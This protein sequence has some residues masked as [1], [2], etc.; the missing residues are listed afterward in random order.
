ML[1]STGESD[2]RRR[3]LHSPNSQVQQR[4]RLPGTSV[5]SRGHIGKF[6]MSYDVTNL[7]SL[8]SLCA[9]ILLAG[10]GKMILIIAVIMCYSPTGRLWE[11]DLDNSYCYWGCVHRWLLYM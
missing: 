8:Q 11:N 5:P 1:Q 9:I 7:S 4:N 2:V 3:P 10:Y 6:H